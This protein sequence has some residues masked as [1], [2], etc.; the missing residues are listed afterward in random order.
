MA[1]RV[2]VVTGAMIGILGCVT[3]MTGLSGIA[4]AVRNV[5]TAFFVDASRERV[6]YC[7]RFIPARRQMRYFYYVENGP[8]EVI[9]RGK[10]LARPPTVTLRDEAG[11]P[12]GGT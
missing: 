3:E 1:A 7:F 12:G 9:S 8:D 11:C 5:R 6:G 2:P 4:T 10:I